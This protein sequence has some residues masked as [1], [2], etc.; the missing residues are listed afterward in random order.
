MLALGGSWPAFAGPPLPRPSPVSGGGRTQAFHRIQKFD[1]S[2]GLEPVTRT[3]PRSLT[4]P[5]AAV[6]VGTWTPLGPTPIADEKNFGP[7]PQTSS[8][9]GRA[10]GRVT[11]LAT[12][13]TDPNIIYLGAAGGGVWKSADGGTSWSTTTD[14]QPSIAIGS[15]AVDNAGTTIYAAT[16]EDNGSGDSQR[17]LGILKS[18]DAGVT[19]TAVGQSTFAQARNGG[20]VADRYIF[21]TTER[22]FAATNNGLFVSTNSGS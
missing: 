3:V 5:N 1:P 11:S 14:S 20:I 13:P 21:G 9:F 22:V 4:A 16:G 12:K 15:L 7:T 18:V 10:S 2:V 17:G 19:W 6:T 8:D